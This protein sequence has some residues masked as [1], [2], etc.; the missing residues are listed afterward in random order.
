MANE[1]TP[2]YWA[3]DGVPLQT[4][5]YNIASWG[6][7]RQAPG[8]MRGS[9]VIVPRATGQKWMA[10]T[11]D[12]RTI[13]L[14]MWVQGCNP[15]GSVPS[16][17][18]ARSLFLENWNMLT[19][20]LWNPYR[21]FVITKRIPKPGTFTHALDSSN[22]F[23]VS[24]KGQF[25]DG[26]QPQ[27]NG[28]L[29]AAFTVDIVMVDPFFYDDPITLSAGTH[30]IAG[31]ARTEAITL[32]LPGGGRMTNSSLNVWV[33]NNYNATAAL[34]VRKFKAT[35]GA[36]GVSGQIQHAGDPYWMVLD[37][38]TQVLAGDGSLTYQP[39]YF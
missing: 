7:S 14:G 24:G 32:S 33:Q 6:G 20:L 31:Q 21:E 3:I 13:T 30:T 37:P 39:R 9:D 22:Y 18:S 11:P 10:K 23:E 2:E 27:M 4:L 36:S 17:G 29:S 28:H 15:D 5:A 25:V 12:A 16:N 1:T 35:A 34:D 38:G 8:P 26:L 19:E